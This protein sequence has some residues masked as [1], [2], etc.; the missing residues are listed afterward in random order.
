MTQ[1]E[2]T[3]IV[4]AVISALLTSGKTLV[5]LTTVDEISENDFIELDGGRKVSYA[6]LRDGIVSSNPTTGDAVDY[7]DRDEITSLSFNGNNG[8]IYIKQRGRTQQTLTIPLATSQKRGLMSDTDLNKLNYSYNK[9][10][11]I[12]AALDDKVSNATMLDL[13]NS[14]L[15]KKVQRKY[16]AVPI[17]EGF[18]SLMSMGSVLDNIDGGS[19]TY[20][21][22]EGD[23]WWDPTNNK[24]YYW[25][26]GAIG[27]N[28]FDPSTEVIYYNNHTGRAYRWTGSVMQEVFVV[29]DSAG[30]IPETQ[31]PPQVLK[32]MGESV[33]NA[34]N[35]SPVA[36]M[37]QP[38]EGD[39]YFDTNS[40]SIKYYGPGG[41]VDLGQP[42]KSMIY[43]NAH[44]NRLYRWSGTAMVE[45][46]N[47]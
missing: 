33:D 17:E 32:S 44:T 41:T 13:Y 21:H 36:W 2:L 11:E 30:R 9:I 3:S 37:Y 34:G 29:L 31:L 7:D 23:A 19:W 6:T 42:S 26:E 18:A 15:V 24:I 28:Y 35:D 20:T 1:Q 40:G 38:I 43:C 27:S 47:N 4:E 8:N 46:G 14:Y 25:Q 12:L 10:A 5:Q 16:R 39:Y 45:V 22:A